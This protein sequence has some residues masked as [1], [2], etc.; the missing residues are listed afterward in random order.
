VAH[1][2]TTPKYERSSTKKEL[3]R[4]GLTIEVLVGLGAAHYELLSDKTIAML[5]PLAFYH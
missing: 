3:R 2:D 4:S 5:N 1:I